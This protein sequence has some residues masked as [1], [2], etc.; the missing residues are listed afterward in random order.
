MKKKTRLFLVIVETVVAI[1]LVGVL[2]QYRTLLNPEIP[3]TGIPLE[4][5]EYQRISANGAPART[6]IF[7]FV[8]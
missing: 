8:F 4:L 2:V 3:T 1:A 6:E 7:L 5:E